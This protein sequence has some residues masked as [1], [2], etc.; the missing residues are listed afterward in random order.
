MEFK[1]KEPRG[2]YKKCRQDCPHYEVDLD[3]ESGEITGHH[4]RIYPE[5]TREESKI[6]GVA[7]INE[8]PLKT[9]AATKKTKSDKQE[10]PIVGVAS[11]TWGRPNQGKKALDM[12]E[13]SYVRTETGKSFWDD[14][15]KMETNYYE[16]GVKLALGTLLSLVAMWFWFISTL[17]FIEL[18]Q[19][20]WDVLDG[21]VQFLLELTK[22][23]WAIIQNV[24]WHAKGDDRIAEGR[25]LRALIII[26][27]TL[28]GT[29]TSIGYI[30][31]QLLAK[32]VDDKPRRPGMPRPRPED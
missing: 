5:C 17:L 22:D 25:F 31:I 7:L 2:M 29:V 28:I 16:L 18:A 15:E 23:S 26:G 10:N 4:C 13:L 1:D 8:I 20:G 3:S 9:T 21:V 19:L 24:D 6:A 27:V 14:E 12:D 30:F 32:Y 11:M